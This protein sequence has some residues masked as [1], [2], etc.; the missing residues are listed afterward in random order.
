MAFSTLFTA[1]VLL[2]DAGAELAARGHSRW[3]P[4]AAPTC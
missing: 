2:S 4:L 1:R 3:P